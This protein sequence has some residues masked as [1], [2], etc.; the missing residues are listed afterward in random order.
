[1]E[2]IMVTTASSVAYPLIGLLLGL[3]VRVVT[4]VVG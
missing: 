1:M 4:G 2:D 3:M